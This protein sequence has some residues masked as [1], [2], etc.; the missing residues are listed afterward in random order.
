MNN[1]NRLNDWQDTGDYI[2]KRSAQSYFHHHQVVSATAKALESACGAG[3]D[4]DKSK[5]SACGSAC[6]A[7]DD[8]DKSKPSACGSACGAGDDPDKSKPSACG[9]GG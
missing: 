4:P 9:S 7:E 2:A 8:P 5:P 1:L 3:D 6:G